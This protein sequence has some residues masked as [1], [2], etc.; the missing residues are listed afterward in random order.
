MFFT[1]RLHKSPEGVGDG[2]VAGMSPVARG[3]VFNDGV[4]RRRC[5]GEGGG[6]L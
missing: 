2:W 6:R 3:Y 5:G 4:A 1:D